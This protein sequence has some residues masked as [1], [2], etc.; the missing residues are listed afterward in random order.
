[1][2]PIYALLDRYPA[3]VY[4][5]IYGMRHITIKMKMK[6]I[7]ACLNDEK[8]F[9]LNKID[10]KTR[11]EKILLAAES[12]DKIIAKQEKKRT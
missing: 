9:I 4:F 7:L 1:M 10:P 8:E 11:N 12:L 3:Y 2:N 5:Q 6:I